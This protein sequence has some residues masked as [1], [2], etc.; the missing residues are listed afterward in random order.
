MDESSIQLSCV[1][2]NKAQTSG[3]S[4]TGVSLSYPVLGLIA[5]A[6]SSLLLGI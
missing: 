6:T 2:A 1:K 4:A 3:E 5:I